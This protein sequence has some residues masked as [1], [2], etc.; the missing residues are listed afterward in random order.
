MTKHEKAIRE[1][2]QVLSAAIKAA[3][4]DGYA[5]QWPARAEGLETI[6]VSSTAKAADSTPSTAAKEKAAPKADPK[7][8]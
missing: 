6:A 8:P 2:A 4:K 7:Q 1:A 3:R 5:V